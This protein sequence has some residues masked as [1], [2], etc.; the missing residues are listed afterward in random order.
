[1]SY[2]CCENCFNE[3]EE[4]PFFAHNNKNLLFLLK[5]FFNDTID[6]LRTGAVQDAMKVLDLAGIKIEDKWADHKL[7]HVT[8]RII[9]YK[10]MQLYPPRGN[11]LCPRI[12]TL[13]VN[14]VKKDEFISR[15]DTP[16]RA[17]SIILLFFYTTYYNVE[18]NVYSIVSDGI[19]FPK[20]HPNVRNQLNEIFG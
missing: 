13:Y 18:T 20:L 1:M 8:N 15:C 10:I 19:V 3:H 17:M 7:N 5:N 6:D 11:S 4:N 2:T 9:L 14:N 16:T 12:R